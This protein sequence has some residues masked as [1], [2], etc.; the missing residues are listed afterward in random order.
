[1]AISL[2]RQQ[3]AAARAAANQQASAHG[4]SKAASAHQLLKA[5]EQHGTAS[6]WEHLAEDEE[7]GWTT[8]DT[9]SSLEAGF[10]GDGMPTP[11]RPKPRKSG[12]SQR[13][14]R[15]EL[16]DVPFG[17]LV[18]EV[19]LDATAGAIGQG[20]VWFASA[21]GQC[22]TR[23]PHLQHSLRKGWQLWDVSRT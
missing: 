15:T 12:I 21:I 23:V 22:N 6:A 3:Q 17:M 2:F 13:G 7:I 18:L 1:M 11:I 10:Y 8:A 19:L 4:C 5:A 9:S 14:S 16:Q 20:A